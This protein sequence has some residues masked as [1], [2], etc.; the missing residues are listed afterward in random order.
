MPA[1]RAGLVPTDHAHL[2]FA[3]QEEVV[4]DEEVAGIGA[5]GP[6]ADAHVL[7]TAVADGQGHRA[8]HFLLAREERDVGVAE[9]ESFKDV[10]V[11]GHDVEELVVARAVKDRFAVAGAL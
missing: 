7:E 1:A 3:A 4:G 2:V 11:G 5:L 9:G 10:V 6:H 8:H